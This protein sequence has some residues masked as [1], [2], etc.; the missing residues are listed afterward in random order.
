MPRRRHA[1]LSS[2]V[3]NCKSEPYYQRNNRRGSAFHLLINTSAQEE[4]NPIHTEREQRETRRERKRGGGAA[5]ERS[6]EEVEPESGKSQRQSH[7]RRW[8][9]QVGEVR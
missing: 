8:Q 1:K 5:E 2:C 6:I 3:K 9:A 4:N 7:F